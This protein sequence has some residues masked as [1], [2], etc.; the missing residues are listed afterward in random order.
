MVD[1]ISS[2][3]REYGEAVNEALLESVEENGLRLSA[4]HVVLSHDS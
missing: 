1:L 3:G 2:F 4:I